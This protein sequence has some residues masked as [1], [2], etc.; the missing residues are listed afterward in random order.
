MKKLRHRHRNLCR[1][2][3]VKEKFEQIR[4]A[5]CIKPEAKVPVLN[6]VCDN[7]RILNK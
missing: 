7:Y 6:K 2:A 5:E 1:L 4:Q 3:Y